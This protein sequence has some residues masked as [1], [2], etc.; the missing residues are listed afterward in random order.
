MNLNT[1]HDLVNLPVLESELMERPMQEGP[2]HL[3]VSMFHIQFDRHQALAN[4]G[5]LQVMYKFLDKQDNVGNVMATDRSI[6]F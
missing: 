1:I 2:A 5:T 6:L 4:E 3:V